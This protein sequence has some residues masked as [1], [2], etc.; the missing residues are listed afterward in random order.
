MSYFYKHIFSSSRLQMFFKIGALKNFTILRVK[1]RLQHKCF[2][3]RS[4]HMMLTCLSCKYSKVFKNSFFIEHLQRLQIFFKTV[5]LKSS[6]NFS[7]KQLCWSLFLKNLQAES[8]QLH[9]KT[10]TQVFSCEV[11]KTF[12]DIFCYRTPLV[13][14]SA[15]PMAASAFFKK[16]LLNSYFAT[17][18]TYLQFFL[19]DKSF[20]V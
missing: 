20:D 9:R 8:L 11:C 12:K 2:P 1:K 13:T 5:F 6:A 3:V 4:S 18:L 15:R 19:L 16:A 17:L 10:P 7:G 14:A